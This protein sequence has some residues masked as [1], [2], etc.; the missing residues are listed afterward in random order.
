MELSGCK[1]GLD[2]GEGDL[3]ALSALQPSGEYS[4]R[5]G[6]SSL[7]QVLNGGIIILLY[8]FLDVA[9]HDNPGSRRESMNQVSND[10]RLAGA[11]GQC[12]QWPPVPAGEVANR[13]VD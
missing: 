10:Q 11:S 3:S 7:T 8:D 5:S 4:K 13:L 12:Y 6:A 2:G 9:N 1:H